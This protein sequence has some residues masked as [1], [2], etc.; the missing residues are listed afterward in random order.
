ME[1]LLMFL[2][3]VTGLFLILIVLIQRGRGGGLAGAFGGAGGQSAFGTKAGD[4]FTRVTIGV[5]AFWI[6]LCAVSVKI[7]S[8][9]GTLFSQ[10]GGSTTS[11]PGAAGK[12]EEVPAK[13]ADAA[14][15]EKASTDT[16]D[17][18]ATPD[19]AAAGGNVNPPAAATQGTAPSAAPTAE[20]PAEAA[21]PAEKASAEK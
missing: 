13:G 20:A 9:T 4:L 10:T 19:S 3:V 6:I 17:T 18:N 11:A 12:S 15:P 8:N 2:L 7:L 5:A 16:S 1:Y 14:S 21:P